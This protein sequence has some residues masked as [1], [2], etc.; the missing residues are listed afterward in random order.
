MNSPLLV[1]VGETG[2][3]KTALAI[4]LAKRF[5]GEII[6]A[7]SRTVYT[8]MDIGTAKPTLEERCGIPH[9]GFDVVEPNQQFTAYDF[10]RLAQQAID[11]IAGRG[12]LPI[13]V[14]G[15]GL[16]ID[17]LLYNF[18]FRPKPSLSTR[19]Q[20]QGLSIKEL[21]DRILARNLPMPVNRN[22]SRHLT[23]VLESEGVAGRRTTLRPNTLII[24]ISLP[25]GGLP[26]RL[27]A[28]INAMIEAG[29]VDEVR[30]LR[31]TYGTIEA[32]RAPGYT[33]MAAY[34][35]GTLSLEEAKHEFLKADASLAKR[36]RTWFK[37][38]KAIHWLD[39]KN[40][41]DQAE[42]LISMQFHI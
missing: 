22:N 23:R 4:A 11:D 7:D 40:T 5:H 33:A 20:L 41:L 14:G 13:V 8:G 39:D 37:R 21:Q 12:K 17:A 27:T 34:L 36:Q 16:Y 15:T 29:L 19:V 25:R 28:R 32:F 26:A 2:S 1:I 35:D 24:G 38:N 10:Q 30:R 31:A 6:A 18:T 3:G 42:R 9:Y